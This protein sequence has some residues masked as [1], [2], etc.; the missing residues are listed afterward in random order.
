LKRIRILAA[1]AVAALLPG[2]ASDVGAAA[3]EPRSS[4]QVVRR[5]NE[6]CRGQAFG[7]PVRH[8]RQLAIMHT[9]MH[10]A[11]NGV[12]PRYERH[13]SDLSDPGA[14]AEAAA[15]AAAHRVLVNFFP[16]NQAALDAELETSLSTIPP[17]P[18]R[19]AGVA[20]GAAV[21]QEA[22]DAR[23][24]DGFDSIDPFVP[25]VGP[26]FWKPT[27]PAFS[28]MVEPQFQN[29]QPFG[30]RSREQFEV[31]A[32]KA[33]AITS[34][35][36]AE[37]FAEVKSAGDI[38]SATR[39][40]DETHYAH[41]WFEGSTLGWSRIASVVSEIE[42]Y[43]LHRTARLLALV[44][45]AMADGFISGFH[46]KRFHAFWRP[47]TAIRE[48]DTDAN[49]DTAQDP[50]WTPLRPTPASPEYPSTHSVLGAAAA[51]VLRRFTGSDHHSFCFV[52]TTSVPAGSSRCFDSLSQARDENA[53]SRVKVGIHFR[54]ACTEGLKLGKRI[55]RFTI[56]HNLRPLRRH[57]SS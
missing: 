19:D 6:V 46:W 32:P 25:P 17:G 54:T 12:E 2:A 40:P 53:D 30:I 55:G 1:A 37:E 42:D 43:D 20:L 28:P 7:N 44:N 8:A 18:A 5:W 31:K 26:G 16:A 38:N 29:V 33:I 34:R 49:P 47:V 57:G 41:F 4:G 48:A 56:R 22:Y 50:G 14:N 3:W 21:G 23:L 10:D 11:V 9:A 52:S 36:Y 35:R 45:M 13:R 27:P 15:A 39:T 24:F 51:E